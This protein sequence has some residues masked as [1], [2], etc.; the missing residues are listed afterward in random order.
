[1]ARRLE[2]AASTLFTTKANGHG[3][4]LHSAVLAANFGGEGNPLGI[5]LVGVALAFEVPVFVLALARLRILTAAQLR[6][7]LAAGQSL[8]D[9]AKAAAL[10]A[11]RTMIEDTL[12][13]VHWNRRRAAVRR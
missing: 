10:K 11:E 6:T 8:A 5:G 7:K 9:V 2:T 3:F 1:M 12:Q 4:G 13:Q